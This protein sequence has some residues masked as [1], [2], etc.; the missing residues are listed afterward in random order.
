MAYGVQIT[1]I[2]GSL[3]LEGKFVR[4]GVD[5][6]YSVHEAIWSDVGG[7]VTVWFQCSCP[8]DSSGPG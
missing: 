3:I 8:R 5:R 6:T 7:D 2:E 4:V 1:I